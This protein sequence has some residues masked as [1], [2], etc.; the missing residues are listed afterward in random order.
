MARVAFTA[1]LA[2]AGTTATHAAVWNVQGQ[3]SLYTGYDDNVRQSM[4]DAP[5]TAY[6]GTDAS[7]H[8]AIQNP[9]WSASIDPRVVRVRYRNYAILNRTENYLNASWQQ[10]AETSNYELSAN[11]TRDTTLTS[12][13]GL[14]GLAEA[15]KHHQSTALTWVHSTQWTERFLT[16]GLLFASM[17]RY[18]DAA[19]T[20]LVDYNYGS[21]QFSMQYA[22][23]P[24]SQISFDVNAGKLQVPDLVN[25]DKV[26]QSLMMSYNLAF[27]E[28]WQMKIS[29]GPSRVQAPLSTESGTVY[30]FSLN[31]KSEISSLQLKVARDITPTG[32][33]ILAR[34]EQ[35]ILSA[36]RDL[37]ERLSGNIKVSSTQNDNLYLAYAVTARGVRYDE[38]SSSIAWRFTPQIVIGLNAGYTSQKL[39]DES[40]V[41]RRRY[42]SLMINWLG[43]VH[44]WN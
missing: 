15:N 38:L 25:V 3:A 28:R 22:L 34:R 29:A 5:E 4:R 11:W 44:T 7:L 33:G 8:L 36:S 27:A 23:T 32:Q 39:Q 17:H 6:A 21:A 24:R 37:T 19:N 30:E 31:R 42:A 35:W 14:T 12:E 1:G 10:Q 18:A 16:Q 2:I 13:L 26:N 9:V 41:V 20:G 43:A 40:R